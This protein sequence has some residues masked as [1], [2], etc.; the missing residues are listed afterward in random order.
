MV[1]TALV[2]SRLTLHLLDDTS[3]RTLDYHSSDDGG[4]IRSGSSIYSLNSPGSP[5]SPEMQSMSHPEWPPSTN[6]EQSS[7]PQVINKGQ[8]QGDRRGAQAEPAPAGSRSVHPDVNSP[9]PPT[10]GGPCRVVSP[11]AGLRL[12]PP[13]VRPNVWG[14]GRHA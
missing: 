13:Q 14:N 4:S 5:N 11:L 7:Q 3:G 12:E 8:S 1:L 6:R 9:L 10:I 2:P